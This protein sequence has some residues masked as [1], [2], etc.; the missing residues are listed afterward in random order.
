MRLNRFLASAGLGSRRA[1]DELIRQGRIEVN[2]ETAALP[3]P[4]VVPGRDVVA[5]DGE[6]LRL[7]QKWVYLALYK[8][9]GV[10]TTLSDERGR[11]C[12]SDLL[13]SL[14]GRVFPIG[15]LDR[16]S[17]GLLLLTNNGELAQRLLLPRYQQERIYHV[18]L[19]P[20]PTLEQ[21][22]Q[23]HEGVWI[24]P[25]EKSGQAQVRLLG[26]KKDT[27]RVKI[28]LREGKNREVRRIFAKIG[29]EVMTLRRMTYAGVSLAGLPVGTWRPLTR[30]EI[31][32]LASRTHLEL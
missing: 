21:L 14:K 12:I 20:I 13:G 19:R 25:R 6:R 5:C 31:A 16:A 32:T 4:D 27:G 8:P 1:C 9:P 28:T 17:E 29:C 15:R 10:L 18:W 23:V 26:H 7:P 2:G 11:P 30:E 3:G 24:G 22:R